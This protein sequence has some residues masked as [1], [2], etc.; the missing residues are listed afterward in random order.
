[1][2][3]ALRGIPLMYP[4]DMKRSTGFIIWLVVLG[5]VASIFV[6]WGGGLST[7]GLPPRIARVNGKEID[8]TRF[9]LISSRYSRIYSSL[10]KDGFDKGTLER[11]V[12]DEL[13]REMILANEAERI[14]IIV[15]DEEVIQKIKEGFTT[16]NGRFDQE[17]F[18]RFIDGL[19]QS[20]LYRMEEE[21]RTNLKIQKLVDL[22]KDTVVVTDLE[23]E[24][25][26]RRITKEPN[27]EDFSKR[28]EDLREEF[29]MEKFRRFYQEWYNWLKNRAKIEINP[30]FQR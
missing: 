16:N 2:F 23:V 7:Q 9:R 30:R 13:I 4:E 25:Y 21:V 18:N 24:D 14:G 22:L 28:K 3:G 19:P 20:E 29:A 12:L 10:Y 17:G 5:F 8:E 11:M 6:Y 1:M 27:D 26:Y 15:E